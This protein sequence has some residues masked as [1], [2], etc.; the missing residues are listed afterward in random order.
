MVKPSRQEVA[1]APLPPRRTKYSPHRWNSLK[2]FKTTLLF[3]HYIHPCPCV[4]TSDPNAS[5]L[6]PRIRQSIVITVITPGVYTSDPEASSPGAAYSPRHCNHNR[7][8]RYSIIQDYPFP[9]PGVYTSDP[10][11]YSPGPRIRQEIVITVATP[12]SRGLVRDSY[13]PITSWPHLIGRL[14]ECTQTGRTL[15]DRPLELSMQATH[16]A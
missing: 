12:F 6:G 5:L 4:Y 14:Q 15:L 1:P 11:V 2:P 10:E 13:T 7:Y 8:A 16:T 3:N 9:C